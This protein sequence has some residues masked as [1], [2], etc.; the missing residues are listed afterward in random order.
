[1]WLERAKR[2]Q[3]KIKS[4]AAMRRAKPF[5]AP[6][7]E[8]ELRAEAERLFRDGEMPSLTEL[9]Q[10]VL[11]SRKKYSNKI[12]RARREAKRKVSVN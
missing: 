7:S 8:G 6:L 2:F 3:D 4:E 11:L 1:M 10:A 9:A 12:R 5:I